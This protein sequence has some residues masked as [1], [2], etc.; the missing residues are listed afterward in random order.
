[1]STWTSAQLYDRFLLYLG[2]GNGGVMDA[3]EL[4]TSAR[5]YTWLADAQES[6]YADLAPRAPGAF[7]SAPVQ[8]TSADSGVT[9]TYGT[10]VYPFGHVEV[11][12][13]ERAGRELFASS[14]GNAGGDFVIEGGRIRTPGNRARTYASG[15]WARFTAF[16]AAISASVEPSLEPPQARELILFK[17]LENAADV[18]AGMMDA[19]VWSAKYEAARKKWLVVWQT[20]YATQ[21]APGLPGAGGVWWL[22]LEDMN[23][24]RSGSTTIDGG[25]A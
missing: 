22:H 9:F 14:Y 5:A 24:E 4:W 2:R 10:N 1:M 17:A 6:V 13:R 3:D 7:V 23:G 20:Q 15:P 25:S 16:P 21:G 18:S 19:S 12:A 11:Y 8:L